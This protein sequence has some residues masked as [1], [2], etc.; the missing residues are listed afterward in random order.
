M[1]YFTNFFVDMEHCAILRR[2]AQHGSYPVI[3]PYNESFPEHFYL[4]RT[5]LHHVIVQTNNFSFPVSINNPLPGLWFL[6]AFIPKGQEKISQKGLN[7]HNCLYG[8]NIEVVSSVQEDLEEIDMDKTTSIKLTELQSTKMIRYIPQEGIHKYTLVIDKCSIT[9]PNITTVTSCPVDIDVSMETLPTKGSNRTVSHDCSNS[10]LPCQIDIKNPVIMNWN[11][12]KITSGVD[13]EQVTSIELHLRFNVKNYH[14]DL[15]WSTHTKDKC[16]LLM[17]LGRLNFAKNDFSTMFVFADATISPVPNSLILVPDSLVLVAYFKLNADTDSGGT[18]KVDLETAQDILENTQDGTIWFC[19]MKNVIPD[20]SSV[21]KC[22]GGIGLTVNTTSKAAL[23]NK[24]YIPYPEEGR[25]YFGINSQCYHKNNSRSIERCKHFPVLRLHLSVS[26]CVDE[27]CGQFGVCQEFIS[28]LL[29]FS[30]CKCYAGWRGYGCNDGTEAES[31]AAM[32]T[33]T[34]LLTLSNLLFIPGII[35][36]CYSRYFV[37]ALVY[38]YTMFFSTF[39]HACD[40]NAV[41]HHYCMMKYDVLSYCDFLG[42]IMSFWV[43]ILAMARIKDGLR[44]FL[45]MLGALCLALGV[46]YDRHGLWV[47]VVPAV[48]GVIIMFISWIVQCQKRK[49][50]YPT[51]WRYVKFLLPGVL[52]AGTGLVIFAFLETEENYKYTHS[53]WHVVMALCIIFLLPSRSNMDKGTLD[54]NSHCNNIVLERY[55]ND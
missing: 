21:K 10:S 30:S 7:K 38:T 13:F 6:A 11:Y 42:S 44:S 20:L 47:F 46:E 45:H 17:G 49:S 37:E 19:M 22:T 8:L 51:K 2:Y 12:L 16:I 23:S 34:L 3:R 52:L 39:Y 36:A 28:G 35:I 29:V 5:N 53:A 43:T 48:T 50:C 40:T 33:S 55:S 18:F 4:N 24:I 54:E 27:Q 9:G 41:V 31:D 25:W 14:P 26:R 32:L 15:R 1:D